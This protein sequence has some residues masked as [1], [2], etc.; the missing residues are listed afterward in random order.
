MA[1]STNVMIAASGMRSTPSSST[2][3]TMSPNEGIA[4][5]APATATAT[6]RPLPVWPMSQP[7]GT[8]ITAAITTETRVK[9][10]CWPNRTG[11]A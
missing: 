10:M 6:S 9:Y 8:A 4:L 11:S 3:S 2:S 7:S 5:A 1:R